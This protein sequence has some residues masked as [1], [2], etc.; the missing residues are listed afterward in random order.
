MK[1][2][3][4]KGLI[5]ILFA[6]IVFLSSCISG[7]DNGVDV[8]E[9]HELPSNAETNEILVSQIDPKYEKIRFGETQNILLLDVEW[10]TPESYEEMMLEI[11]ENAPDWLLDII[12]TTA[13]KIKNGEEYH[14]KM[15]NGKD[16]YLFSSNPYN[17]NL[18]WDKNDVSQ[19]DPDG[20]YIFNMYPFYCGVGY[21]DEN[22]EWHYKDF[23]SYNEK[24]FYLTVDDLISYCDELLD[25]GKIT[26][27]EY[28][29]YAIKSPLER[30]VRNYG[31]F[32]EEDLKNYPPNPPNEDTFPPTQ[33]LIKTKKEFSILFI[34]N[35]LVAAGDM[36]SQVRRLSDMYGIKVDYNTIVQ[37][38][39]Y[40]HDTMDQS[41]R[42]MQNNQYD[43]VVLQDGGSLPADNP[44][45]FLSN[46][47][48]LCEEARKSGAIP[49]LYNPAWA[50]I[51]RKPNK[52][53]QAS[54]TASYER[55]AKIHGAILVNAADA[56]VYAYDKHP[57][58]NLYADDVHANDAGAYLTACVFVSTLFE[59]HVKDIARNN[60]YHG[61]DAI[62]LGQAAWEYV[63]Y[64][65]EHK[66]SPTG[67]VTVPDG[68]NE[69]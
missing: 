22:G 7:D 47:E 68:T 25:G 62:R 31:W 1:N 18:N 65:N 42:K 51:D 66:K 3:K 60:T 19:I 48:T 36:P 46:I 26:Q 33:E 39:A 30:Y 5:S 28:D 59:L 52:E 45:A 16:D 40:L 41:I 56:W 58:L 43:Y 24:E 69:R 34:G 57:D 10:H 11:N 12:K 4:T 61:D 49:V 38:G 21:L 6:V 44:T 67:N 64:Y 37:G 8:T 50:N 23:D 54:L 29:R 13:K 32:G 53:Y 63:R 14:A 17:N 2:N 9:S 55:A 27:E 20:Y 35:S 15:V